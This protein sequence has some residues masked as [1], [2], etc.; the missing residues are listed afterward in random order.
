MKKSYNY[1]KILNIICILILI[2]LS[3][4][5]LINWASIPNKIPAHYNALGVIDRWGD[6]SEL[7]I[8]PIISWVLYIMITVI[9][10]FPSIWNTGVKVTEKNREEVYSIIRNM[11]DILKLVI[12]CSFTYITINSI[13]GIELSFWFLPIEL[14]IIFLPIIYFSIKLFKVR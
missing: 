3:I 13:Y 7:L 9:Q 1:S 11:I 2:S 6:K 8:L 14:V 10:Q 5:L 12:V 4:Y